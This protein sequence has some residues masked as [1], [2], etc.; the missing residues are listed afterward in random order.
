M[1]AVIGPDGGTLEI[2]SEGEKRGSNDDV[3]VMF[4]V[5]EGSLTAPVEIVMTVEGRFLSELKISFGPDG[6]S[7]DPPAKLRIH[8]GKDLLDLDPFDITATHEHGDEEET[9]VVETSGRSV[10]N[11]RLEL[12]VTGFSRYSLGN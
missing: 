4:I 12:D 3:R 5:P 6:T 1:S 10:R 8:L 11:Y 2:R 9:V 7:F